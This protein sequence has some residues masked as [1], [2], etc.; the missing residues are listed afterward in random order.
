M[1]IGTIEMLVLISLGYQVGQ[2]MGWTALESVFLGAAMSISNSAMLVKVLRDAGQ[3]RTD[4]GRIVVGIPV[5]EDFV[6]V[7]FLTLLSGIATTGTAELRD[8]GFLDPQHS[9]AT[10]LPT[11]DGIPILGNGN[12]RLTHLRTAADGI[13]G[14]F[15][16]T[17]NLPS[18]AELVSTSAASGKPPQYATGNSIA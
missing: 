13:E 11:A 12:Q 9:D 4:V 6:A 15:Q 8:I 18:M 16:A 5:V 1:L 2:L 17:E 10:Y 7:I 3:L 14:G